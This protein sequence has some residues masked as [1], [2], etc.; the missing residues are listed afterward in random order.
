MVFR[1]TILLLS[2]TLWAGLLACDDKP[3]AAPT[4][5]SSIQA[6]TATSSATASATPTVAVEDFCKRM[7]AK[8][9]QCGLELVEALAKTGAKRDKEEVAKARAAAPEREAACRKACVKD[10][11]ATA[12]EQAKIRQAQACLDKTVCKQLLSCIEA[13]NAAK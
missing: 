5:A 11:P 12:N 13:I 3:T 7:C 6:T 4:T 1:P 10:K 2:L 9:S 8:T